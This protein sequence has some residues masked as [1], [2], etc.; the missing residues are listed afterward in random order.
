MESSVP[1]R[2]AVD[3]PRSGCG[4]ADHRSPV[5]MT[6]GLSMA[7]R[8]AQPEHALHPV[9]ALHAE[10][11]SRAV[12]HSLAYHGMSTLTGPVAAERGWIAS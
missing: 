4:A 2:P 9:T 6:A 1:E 7:W 10:R 3:P 11:R 5:Q 12:R 8:Q